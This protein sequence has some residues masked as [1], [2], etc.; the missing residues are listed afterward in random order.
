MGT[1]LNNKRGFG[2]SLFALG[3]LVLLFASNDASAMSKKKKYNPEIPPKDGSKIVHELDP[4]FEVRARNLDPS[5]VR[6]QILQRAETI[7]RLF[8][9][10]LS[11]GTMN[12]LHNIIRHRAAFEM[13][14]GE[15]GIMQQSICNDH[16]RSCRV[17]ELDV[18]VSKA[19][20]FNVHYD[21]G[22]NSV[23]YA[24]LRFPQQGAWGIAL[25]LD[26]KKVMGANDK[27]QFK[28]HVEAKI[29]FHVEAKQYLNMAQKPQSATPGLFDDASIRT[30]QYLLRDLRVTVD[31]AD[32]EWHGDGFFGKQVEV[33]IKNLSS[34]IPFNAPGIGNKIVKNYL[35]GKLETMFEKAVNKQLTLFNAPGLTGYYDASGDPKAPT[36]PASEIR[37]PDLVKKTKDKQSPE[38]AALDPMLESGK[39]PGLQA[40]LDALDMARQVVTFE[41]TPPLS[42]SAPSITFPTKAPPP[43]KTLIDADYID[44]V[45]AP[46]AKIPCGIND[47]LII[48]NP[49]PKGD[50]DQGM[51]PVGGST[52]NS[53]LQLA[54]RVSRL[55]PTVSPYSE[56]EFAPYL[57]MSY[58][59]ILLPRTTE[60][61]Q[62]YLVP[63]EALLLSVKD[64]LF[65]YTLLGGPALAAKAEKAKN[66][67]TK[68]V[69]A[70][71]ATNADPVSTATS[72]TNTFINFNNLEALIGRIKK[73]TDIVYGLQVSM[74][75]FKY[76]LDA[77]DNAK[78]IKTALAANQ[79]ENDKKTSDP[80]Y[81]PKLVDVPAPLAPYKDPEKSALF[82]NI[83][84]IGPM[85]EQLRAQANT[86]G[87]D[88][89]FLPI[90][91][92]DPV[93]A[94]AGSTT[95]LAALRPALV[96]Q[97][98]NFYIAAI[99]RVMQV[100]G[101]GLGYFVL[102][103]NQLFNKI[104]PGSSMAKSET[105]TRLTYNYSSLAGVMEE[106]PQ[107]QA[108][109]PDVMVV[110]TDDNYRA[111][112]PRAFVAG[113]LVL[114]SSN[115][116]WD[117]AHGGK[118][119]IGDA[120]TSTSDFVVMMHE[121]GHT[122]TLGP[123]ADEYSESKDEDPA[124]AGVLAWDDQSRATG[125]VTPEYPNGTPGAKTTLV[126]ADGKSLDM[127]GMFCGPYLGSEPV[128]ANT[129][130]NPKKWSSMKGPDGYPLYAQIPESGPAGSYWHRGIYHP[131]G[132][133]RMLDSDSPVD[134]CPVCMRA[135]R[136]RMTT[137]ITRTASLKQGGAKNCGVFKSARTGAVVMECS[138]SE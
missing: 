105:L 33:F 108:K 67:F 134:Y 122:R 81:T 18:D 7:N 55:M 78:D 54:D 131:T 5:Q 40:M 116:S 107:Y 14:Y 100:T 56:E 13:I 75:K 109:D 112:D 120:S 76:P 68:A 34:M 36:I 136:G 25:R 60:K 65:A 72:P 113:D 118:A 64:G 46:D 2:A 137:H 26:I 88:I 83:D 104:A 87:V 128:A 77:K 6:N 62:S 24:T 110:L 124:C 51:V 117:A 43:G 127:P 50:R 16:R 21:P 48:P 129:S 11:P 84:E 42:P 23:D 92:F 17:T 101:D 115:D 45:F 22:K 98:E 53:H 70:N 93:I 57:R 74:A 15:N 44:L 96:K 123:L 8:L 19:P 58:L 39:G 12:Y 4:V 90:S 132:S 121:L 31:D 47:Q 30:G 29:K 94:Q 41:R 89:S 114:F 59:N 3:A 35:L 95:D 106:W 119:M 49:N 37:L 20:G 99:S 102:A 80:A 97:W 9:S 28:G 111:Q 126:G 73:T 135:V 10:R 130:K 69:K 82:K 32:V 85:I 27:M 91:Y 71:V 79:A 1:F 86:L 66:D 125:P 103:P 61:A 38:P 138:R 63:V 133:C 52:C